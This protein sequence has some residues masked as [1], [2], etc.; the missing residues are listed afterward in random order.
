[1]EPHSGTSAL[2]KET[3]THPLSMC[4]KDGESEP[5]KRVLADWVGV[6]ISDSGLQSWEQDTP[7]VAKPPSALLRH[8]SLN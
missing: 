4:G 2:T 5:R 3:L 1:M 8:R 6:L 7:A